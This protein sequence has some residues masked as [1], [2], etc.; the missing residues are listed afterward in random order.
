MDDRQIPHPTSDL[1]PMND[2]LI[3]KTYLS[4]S[5]VSWTQSEL[6]TLLEHSRSKNRDRGITGAMMHVQGYFLQ[7][8][9]GPETAVN[10]V[11]SIIEQDPRHEIASILY[12]EIITERHFPN[13]VMG[14]RD[15]DELG[16]RAI[17]TLRAAKQDTKTFPVID[18]LEC[19]DR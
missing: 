9:E 19:F 1:N 11:F 6:E 13:W 17:M 8:L 16:D 4:R 3:A 12:D 7:L 2:H 14:Y 5:L 18:F 15:S 10:T